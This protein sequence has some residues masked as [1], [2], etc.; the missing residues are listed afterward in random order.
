MT[1]P[2][3]P[4]FK[5]EIIPILIMAI[6]AAAS[7]YFYSRFPA[8]VPTHWNFAGQV[9][10]WGSAFTA[11][12]AIP[13]MLVGMYLLFLF[14]PYLDPKK[15]R[16]ADFRRPYHI[17]KGVIIFFLAFIYFVA[18][19]NA[20]GYNVPVGVFTPVMVGIL[21]IVIGNYM[22]KFK[23]N[24]FIG[25][26]NPWTLSNEEV[27]NKTNRLTGKLFVIGG[28][29]MISEAFVPAVV[30]LPLF[31]AVIAGIVIVPTVYSYILYRKIGAKK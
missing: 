5:T 28:L 24:W 10:G 13:L 7:F 3:K 20:L 12:F 16:Y 9:D 29:L 31:I 4:N 30:G 27:W 2:T 1:N 26:R 6:T 15:E 8:R 19:F 17:F 11:A 14:I 18:S 21:F 25:M 22:G 23:S